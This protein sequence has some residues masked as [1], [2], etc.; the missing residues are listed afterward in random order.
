MNRTLLFASLIVV[1]ATPPGRA[2]PTPSLFPQGYLGHVALSDAIK[3]VATTHP[4]RVRVDSLAK[5]A[6]G[7]DV[8]LVTIGAGAGA[9]GIEA[10]AA[11]KPAVLIVANLEADH[12]VGSHVAL[13]MVQKLAEGDGLANATIY[14]VPRLNPDGA[15]RV[16]TG[17]PSAEFRTN[18]RAIDRDRDGRKGEDGPDDINGDGLITLMRV[19]D[20]K[21]ATLIAD[22]KDPR[23]SRKADAAKGEHA[24]FSEEIEGRDEDGDGVRNEDAVGGVNLNRNWPHR[25][26]EFELEAGYS[27][28]SE[29]EVLGL[30][31][32]AFAHPEI[33]A[34]WSFSLN[35]NLRDEPKKPG[36]TLDDADLPLFVELSKSFVKATTPKDPPK[37][38]SPAG[39][40][41]MAPGATTDGAIGEWAYHQFGVVGLASR[42]Y[43]TPEIPAPPEVKDAKEKAE[44]KDKDKDKDKD[45]E[46]EAKSAIPDDAEAR[47]LYWND[48][49]INGRAFIPFTTADHP[50]LGK[51]EIGGW[52]PGVRLNPPL[53]Q[54]DAIRDTHLIFL[55]E[56]V[57]KLPKLAVSDVK[58]VSKGGGLFEISAM[59]VNEGD[60]PT[61]LA[62]GVRTK[63]APPV[64]VRLET[65]KAKLLA[66]KKLERIDALAGSGGHRQ[67]R[68]LVQA[69]EGVDAVTLDV[70]CAKGG[71][72]ATNVPLK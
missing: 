46:K 69:S 10:N 4:E 55:R 47:W 58:V 23:I 12:V 33:V 65:G 66:G 9:G 14:I 11:K 26:S 41:A 49:V 8:W 53:E 7:R 57:G 52:K 44:A 13:G 22:A 62:Q 29:P 2:Q 25:W 32:F 16:L 60:F 39:K 45:K 68:W 1:L 31:K 27:P 70:S 24:V 18:L 35:D 72:V 5:S 43:T 37:G 28:A 63:S 34:V 36:S 61:A 67:F 56:L 15:E 40:G 3:K 54:I 30:I 17:K 42:L 6:E 59:I 20:P 19:K 71:K 51:V 38:S 50:T 21:T 64:L 48:K